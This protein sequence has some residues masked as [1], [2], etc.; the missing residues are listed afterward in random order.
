M[1]FI[2]RL[3]KISFLTLYLIG[4]SYLII[5]KDHLNLPDFIKSGIPIIF[6][7]SIF[8]F[9]LLFLIVFFYK[10][11]H[12]N[13]FNQIVSHVFRTPLTG[14]SWTTNE[15]KKDMTN[16]EKS[17]LLQNINN[18]TDKL[19]DIVDLF[20]GV[21]KVEDISGYN[22]KATSLRELVEK[23]IIKYRNQINKKSISLD[24]SSFRDLPLLTIDLK[25]I[26]FVIDSMI[27]NAVLYTPVKGK[28]TIN[29]M[30]NKDKLIFYIS[31]T[32]IGLSF[33]NKCRIFTKFYRGTRAR[34]LYTDGLGLRLYLSKKIIKKHKGKIYAKSRGLDKGTTFFLELPY[35]K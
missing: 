25:K 21:K 6:T 8:L 12:E 15:L 30:S 13:E 23:S 24:I 10:N 22:F 3:L 32:G 29:Y 26:H 34:H 17:T 5:F 35:K 18:L 7:I 31:D 16:E 19:V 9:W 20:I 11:R 2:K 33:M 14:I 28:I 27:E 4:I 1:L